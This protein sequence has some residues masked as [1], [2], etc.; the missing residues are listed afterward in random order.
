MPR[1]RRL[2]HSP[3]P[4]GFSLPELMI[5]LVLLAIAI[6]VGAPQLQA[7]Q[8]RQQLRQAAVALAD[9]LEAARAAALRSN[10]PCELGPTSGGCGDPP[11]AP[12]NLAAGIRLEGP[13]S[14]FRFS[15]TGLLTGGPARQELVLARAGLGPRACLSVERPS[16]LVRIGQAAAAGS[17]CRYTS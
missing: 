4:S 13:T 11:L 8:R 7:L 3:G 1:P 17:P 6:G 2:P 12:L 16:A 5:L 14:P 15:A 9:Q 10:Q